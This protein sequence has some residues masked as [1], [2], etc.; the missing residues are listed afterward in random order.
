MEY[1]GLVKGKGQNGLPGSF[2]AAP[3]TE[4]PQWRITDYGMS[5]VFKSV[6]GSDRR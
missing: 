2:A 6:E 1:F 4:T 3:I 5:S